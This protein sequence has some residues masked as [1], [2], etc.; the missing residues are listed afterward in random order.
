M[1]APICPSRAAH[2]Q[3]CLQR[4]EPGSR[5][6]ARRGNSS[7]I[8]RRSRQK[9][10]GGAPP[11]LRPCAWCTR[12][13]CL[14]LPEQRVRRAGS[15]YKDSKRGAASYGVVTIH[16]CVHVCSFDPRSWGQL[17]ISDD[18]RK[19]RIGVWGQHGLGV[20]CI[21]WLGIWQHRIGVR[22][23]GV[24]VRG[25]HGLGDRCVYWLGIWQH[26]IGVREHG[27]G[28]RGQH[29]FGVWRCGQQGLGDR[30]VYWIC[31]PQHSAGVRGR[32]IVVR[33]VCSPWR[34]HAGRDFERLH[35]WRRQ[36]S[37]AARWC[38]SLDRKRRRVK[39]RR[40]RRPKHRGGHRPAT[41]VR[42]H[43]MGR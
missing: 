7:H 4:G 23:H 8:H 36:C 21:F 18:R 30:R 41:K 20:R 33:C 10:A 17:Q 39:W 42:A 22:E 38:R 29:G 25:Q 5:C 34:S 31:V 14:D 28:V 24:G 3:R 16:T 2:S 1:C 32:R 37:S 35:L 19:H 27:V 43:A 13:A 26:R 6:K 9:G 15:Q 11:S 12:L 40:W